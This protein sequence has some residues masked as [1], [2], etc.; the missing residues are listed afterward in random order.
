MALG[1]QKQS[2]RRRIIL[3][4]MAFGSKPEFG[5]WV[6]QLG[7]FNEN[8]AQKVLASV[9]TSLAELGTDSAHARACT[10]SSR[11]T[12]TPRSPRPV[13]DTGSTLSRTTPSAGGS[14]PATSGRASRRKTADYWYGDVAFTYGP[15]HALLGRV[16]SDEPESRHR[17]RCIL[18]V[19][20][21][22]LF[23]TVSVSALEGGFL[24]WNQRASYFTL[25][26]NSKM[27]ICKVL[28]P[29]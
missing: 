4:L 15:I 13:P 26:P 27:R 20:H 21:G 3:G 8:C 29:V 18:Q 23:K 9:D 24:L 28:P 19:G 5:A 11:A 25:C 17:R 7:A 22:A 1:T 14:S 12:S 2:P 16:Q 10:T 6:T